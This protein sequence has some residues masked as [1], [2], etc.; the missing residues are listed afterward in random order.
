MQPHWVGAQGEPWQTDELINGLLNATGNQSCR[1]FVNAHTAYFIGFFLEIAFKLFRIPREP[2]MTR[3][4]AKQ[5]S[6]SHWYDIG[7]AERDFGYRPERSIATALE[8]LKGHHET[9]ER[10][11]S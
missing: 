7:A 6:T 1:K 10:L 8:E 2:P 9:G 4:V 3:F 5:L 11:N